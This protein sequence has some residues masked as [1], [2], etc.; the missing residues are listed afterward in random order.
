MPAKTYS[1]GFA[2]TTLVGPLA[3][4]TITS[5]AV[6]GALPAGSASK[7]FVVEIGPGLATDEKILC[8]GFSAGTVTIAAS[9]RGYDGTSAVDHANGETVR[10]VFDAISAQEDNDHLFVISRDDH[11]Q[12]AKADGTRAITGTQALT[13]ATVSGTLGVTGAAT[14]HAVAASSV[15]NT[16]NE[17]VGGTLGVTGATTLASA[18]VTGNET[19]GGTLGVTGVTTLGTVNAVT[20]AVSG[21][22]TVGGTLGVTGVATLG[23]V[24]AS[25]PITGQILI[26]SG[27]TGATAAGRF[28][29]FNA[30]GPPV[31][32]TFLQGD[33]VSDNAGITWTCTVG[34]TPGTW[35]SPFPVGAWTSFTPTATQGGNNLAPTWDYARYMKIGR[36]VIANCEGVTTGPGSGV[37]VMLLGLPVAGIAAE[38]AVA[39][40]IGTF[41]W[42]SG[43][44]NFTGVAD[45]LSTTVIQGLNGGGSA[46]VVNAM[47]GVSGNPQGASAT[48]DRVGYSVMYEAAS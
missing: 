1:G 45:M 3:L 9:G 4:A 39:L 38:A 15:A 31:S 48:N 29:G 26:P 33:Q 42:R 30:A 35:V 37:N 22:E 19:V 5:F 11:P 34:G 20:A 8:S 44:V 40:P 32:G 21:N 12:Y 46:G 16:G 25:G 17:T 27:L 7:P 10:H 36:L 24:T 41:F 6:A 13:N 43:T 47:G 2:D 18:A 28:V 14:L 23:T